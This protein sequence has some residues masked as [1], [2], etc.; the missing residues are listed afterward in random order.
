MVSDG[1]EGMEV[2]KVWNFGEQLDSSNDPEH[3]E[4]ELE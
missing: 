3:F 4:G 1:I 2:A